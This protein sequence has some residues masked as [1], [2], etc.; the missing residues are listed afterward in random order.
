MLEEHRDLSK[1][2][3]FKTDEEIIEELNASNFLDTHPGWIP[4]RPGAAQAHFDSQM[5]MSTIVEHPYP[6]QDAIDE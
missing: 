2:V 6:N 4:L 5:Q 1:K 3:V